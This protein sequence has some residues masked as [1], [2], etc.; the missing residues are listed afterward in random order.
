MHI[1]LVEQDDDIRTL[2]TMFLVESGYSVS[3]AGD[4]VEALEMAALKVPNVVLSSRIFYGMDGFELC[5]RLRTS[6]KTSQSLIVALTGYSENGIEE[7]A[8]VAGFDQYLL[9]PVSIQNVLMMIEAA[10]N[11]LTVRRT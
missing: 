11:K 5:R 10:E 9:K 3:A 4:P 8:R 2:F 1:L 7:R 6:P